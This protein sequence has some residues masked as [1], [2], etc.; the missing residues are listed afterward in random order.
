MSDVPLRLHI[1]GETAKEGWT[2]L[3]VQPGPHVD[4][5]G[6]CRDLSAYSDGAV[7]EIYASH[8]FEHLG[9]LDDLPQ[10]LKE[11]HRVLAAGGTLRISVPYFETLCRL[12]LHPQ[13]DM[14]Q[15]FALM[16]IAFGGQTDP[17]DHHMV[18]LTLEFLDDYLKV[19]GFT[20]VERVETHDLFDDSSTLEIGGV[21]I[22]L[23]V[24]STK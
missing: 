16:R 3:N 9:Y 2:I 20:S 5:L 1:G 19:A 12:F 11:C 14:E 8:V 21:P 18:G 6:D 4:T 22:S 23:N 7:T 15:R 13:L 10:A 17:Y 24:V